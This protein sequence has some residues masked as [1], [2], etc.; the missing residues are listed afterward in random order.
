[1][2]ARRRPTT[3]RTAVQRRAE[4]GARSKLRRFRQAS[5]VA[6]ALTGLLL[7]VASPQE[8]GIAQDSVTT[9]GA[10]AVGELPDSLAI[11]ERVATDDIRQADGEEVVADTA[12]RDAAGEAT[13]TLR[14]LGRGFITNLPKYL[15]A[16]G[17]LLVAWVLARLIRALLRR[18]LRRWESANAFAAVAGVVIW[19]LAFGIAIS[20]LV[21]DIRALV[22]SLGL[23]GLALSW[24]LQTPIESFTAWLLNSFKGYY[25]VGDR[26]A[27]GEVYGD[28]FRIDFL[29]TTVWEYGSPENPPGAIQAEQPTGR[30]ITFP[31]NEVLTG[32][33]INYTRDFPYVWDELTVAVGNE[34]DISYSMRVL[35]GVAD[36]VIGDYMDEPAQRYQAILQ[37]AGLEVAVPAV[38]QIYVSA[39]EWGT[40]LTIRYLVGAREK[41]KWKS[42]L[43][44]RV[45]GE[46]NRPEHQDQMLPVYPRQQIQLV[47]PDGKV[48]NAPWMG[49]EL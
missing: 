30:L 25:R 9:Q 28:V 11:I 45:I 21:G 15:I 27:V 13:S 31:N 41:R 48:T 1:M 4:Q 44:L 20:V 29:T 35:Q 5:I 32:S 6:V 8:A 43:T 2:R 19:L 12:A 22:G 14:D 42:E 46:M 18:V 24:A 33:V 34:S 16:L 39:S 47:R 37:K 38:P 3:R 49:E 7:L 17:V 10:A 36:Q 26:I 23:V 40:N